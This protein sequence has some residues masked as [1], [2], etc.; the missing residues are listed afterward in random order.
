MRIIAV[1]QEVKRSAI[2][3]PNELDLNEY[4][5]NQNVIVTESCTIEVTIVADYGVT[6][7]AKYYI[8]NANSGNYLTL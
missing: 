5:N 1:T 3:V 6:N 7:N 4:T 2:G 8:M